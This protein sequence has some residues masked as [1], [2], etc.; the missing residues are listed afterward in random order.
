MNTKQP[1]FTR[2]SLDFAGVHATELHD[3]NGTHLTTAT[4]WLNDQGQW[5][6]CVAIENRRMA[7]AKARELAQALEQAADE[8]ETLTTRASAPKP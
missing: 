5:I 7:P 3:P 4:T 1:A 2:T 8:A 6:P